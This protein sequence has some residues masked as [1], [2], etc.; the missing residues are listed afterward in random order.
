MPSLADLFADPLGRQ[1]LFAAG[2]HVVAFLYVLARVSG[3]FIAGPLFGQALLTRQA[4]VLLVVAL[5]LL[6]TSCHSE[7]LG[8]GLPAGA[9]TEG[10]PLAVPGLGTFVWQF[11]A[12]MG[13][14]LV[15]GLGMSLVLSGLQVAGEV[16]DQQTGIALGGVFNPG[17]EMSG[18]PT[19]QMLF[20]LG[21]AVLLLMPVPGVFGEATSG[22][23]AIVDALAGTFR[24]MPPGRGAVALSASQ[25]LVGGLQS[26]LV[27]GLCVATPVLATMAV[28]SLTMGTLGYT[29]PQINVLTLGFPI[30]AAVN[31]LVLA[32]TLSGAVRLSLEWL[33][34]GLAGWA[35]RIADLPAAI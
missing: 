10:A 1:L 33:A 21:T 17:L 32:A 7:L 31:L 20:L 14:G 4:R 35:D 16:I 25:W 8:R 26:S 23:L 5:S 15:L 28:V 29:V 11:A 18:G 30:R 19:G 13:I 22:W 27:L 34:A 3:L 6:L 24:T 12:E 2:E 9:A